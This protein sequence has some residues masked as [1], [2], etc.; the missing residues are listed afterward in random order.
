[1]K[2]L[3]LTLFACLLFGQLQAQMRCK[4]LESGTHQPV[5]GA[6]VMAVGTKKIVAVTDQNG[7][8]VLSEGFSKPVRISYI[9]YKSIQVMPKQQG[10]YYLSVDVSSLQ[11]VVVTAQEGHGLSS[12]STI[13]RQAMEHLQPSSFSD[14]LEL[15]PGGRAHDPHLN[16][17]NT[18]NL[19]EVPIASDQYNTSSLGTRFI[20]DGA[21]VSVNGN[22]QYLSGAVDRTSGKRNFANA[23]VDMRTISTDDIQEVTIVRGIP[24]VQYGDLTSGLVKVKRRKGGNDLSARFKADMDS[25][26]FYLAK[27]FEWQSKKLSLNLSA[28]YLD[29]K[30][31]PRNLLETY[32]RITLSARLNKRWHTEAMDYNGSFNMD[33]G[34]SFDGEKLDP[35]LNKGKIDTYKSKY[36]RFAFNT[37][38]NVAFKHRL[39]LK[40]VNA[41]LS[42]SYQHDVISRTRLVQLSQMTPAV[43][44]TEEGE[45]NVP[46]LPYTYYGTQDVDGKPLNIFAQLNAKLQVPSTIIANTLLVGASW[47]LD[48]NYGDGQIFDPLRPPYTGISVRQRKL[49]TIPAM[50]TLAVYAEEHLRIPFARHTFELNGGIRA[51]QMLNLPTS[52]T[53]HGHWYFDPRMNLGWSFPQFNI[54]KWATNVRIQGGVGQHTK[55]PTMEYLYPDPRYLDIVQL[56]YYHPNNDYRVIN[57]RTFVIDATNKALKPARNLKWEFG[58]DINI[59]G[60]NLS[61]TYFKENMT[62]G[63]RS[64]TVYRTYTFK[65]YDTSGIDPNGITA[66]PDV[67]TLPYTMVQE[68]FGRNEYTNGSQ[69]LKRG[70]EYTFATRRIPS[71]HT[72]LTVNGAWFRTI[73]RNSQ[74]VA[75]RPSAVINNKQIQYVGLYRDNDGVKNEMANT[76]FTFD[77]DIPKLRLGFSLSAQCLWF[78]STQRLPLSN[79]PDQYISPD[80]TIHDWQKEYAN[81]TYLRFLVRNHSA[82]EYKKYIVPFSMNLNLKVTKKLLNDRLNIAMFCN[83][84]LDYTP[85]YEQNGIKIRR[86]VR[87]YFGLEINAKL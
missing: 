37:A 43:T 15:L 65:Q 39:W 26:L 12:V 75:Y 50:S 46:I 33:Y 47:T 29:N 55:N 21:P 5:I 27:A 45:Y 61:V 28:D 76:N 23:G 20:I 58:T 72:R 38:L 36:N 62:S 86:S 80:G 40:S 25:K 18:I 34:G 48:K 3:L 11:E 71:L 54:G 10:I 1:M 35:D 49:S 42:S 83:R 77:T 74:V 31:E 57:V 16:V 67:A 66:A 8:F 24:S 84:I 6:T 78:S 51:S 59:A 82:V 63:F 14:L 56:S 53:M 32:Q 73:Y 44:T 85:D 4:V 7:C 17:P 2:R 70:I 79:E 30:A 87:P 68:L 81:D 52:Y 60:N 41:T 69:T 13:S 22:M 9:G 19:R 64:N